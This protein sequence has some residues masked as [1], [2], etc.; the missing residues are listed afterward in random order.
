[1]SVFASIGGTPT[2]PRG[3]RLAAEFAAQLDAY[4]SSPD[5]SFYDDG[6]S[7]RYYEQ[8]LRHIRYV[9]YPKDGLVTFGASGTDMCDRQ[10]VFKNDKTTKPAKS[11]DLP[12]RSRQRRQGTAIVDYVQL[13]LAHMQKRL[14]AA[15]AFTL[16]EETSDERTE[17]LLEEAAQK[18]EIFGWPNPETGEVVRFAITAKPDGLLDYKAGSSDAARLIFE[19][20]TKASGLRAMNAK[21]D[22][23]GAESSHVRQLIAESLVFGV[24][25]ALIVYE[26]THKPAWFDDTDNAGVTKG[27]KTWLDGRPRPDLRVFHVHITPEMQAALLSDLARQAAIVY[28]GDVPDVTVDMTDSCGFCA[29]TAHCH[30]TITPG[31]LAVLL[32]AEQAYAASDGAGKAVH[33]RLADYLAGVTEVR[34]NG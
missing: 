22:Y 1:M 26:S 25:E 18:R 3:E 21:L 8:K 24:N 32:R 12:F 20:K 10:L 15:A 33:R 13:D 7:R 6:I 29:F 2:Q 11:P 27:Q 28:S 30:A 16:A 5:T 19:Y 17:W 9:P 14:G 31:N 23:K 34:A 4:Y